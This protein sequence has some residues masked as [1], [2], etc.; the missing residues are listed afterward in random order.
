MAS[1]RW[2]ILEY[3]VTCYR[4]FSR[5]EE[6]TVDLLDLFKINKKYKNE[7]SRFLSGVFNG[8]FAFISKQIIVTSLQIANVLFYCL[9]FSVNALWISLFKATIWIM[10]YVF[11]KRK[12]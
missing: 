5:L 10:L 7:D 11:H 2:T 3:F 12:R 9:L 8:N 1:L 4:Y 6:K